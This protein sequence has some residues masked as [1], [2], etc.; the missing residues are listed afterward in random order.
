MGIE[1]PEIVEL[2]HKIEELE[3][4]LFAHP[5]HK[6]GILHSMAS[7]VD[8]GHFISVNYALSFFSSL[9]KQNYSSNGSKEKLR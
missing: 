6:V 9:V 5:L 3:S 8:S 7:L 4:K 2:V 1:D